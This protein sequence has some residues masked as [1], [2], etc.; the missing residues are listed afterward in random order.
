MARHGRLFEQL[1]TSSRAVMARSVLRLHE[2]VNGERG[3]AP[4]VWEELGVLR[5]DVDVER[6]ADRELQVG[7]AWRNDYYLYP[8]GS[9][10]SQL[11]EVLE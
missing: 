10:A 1:D 2:Q 7:V 9:I 4:W 8:L 6:P 3:R 11:A 5:S